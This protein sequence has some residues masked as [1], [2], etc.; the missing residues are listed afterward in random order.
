MKKRIA[1]L[2]STGSIGKTLIDILKQYK[3]D[4]KIVLLTT[5][6]NYKELFKQ[7]KLFK[8]KNVIIS[9]SKIY[10]FCRNHKIYKRFNISNRFNFNKLKLKK[11][12]DYTMS[13]ITGL[14][15]LRPTLELIKYSKKIA[16]ANKESIVCAWDI[17][18]KELKKNKTEFVPV[19]SEHFSLWYGLESNKKKNIER[20]YLTASGGPFLNLPLKKFAKI[21]ISNAT[22][23]PNW[24]M[25]NKISIDSATLMNKVFE[26]IEAKK[27]FEI[28]YNQISILIHSESY[29]HA[30]IKFKDGMSKIVA[31]DTSMEI[32][33]FNT[34]F[35]NQEKLI[36]TNKL[37]I[38]KLN[39][40]NFK[41]VDT[42]KFPVISILKKMPQKNTLFET[43]LVSANDSLVE[44]FLNKKIKFQE[45]SERLIKIINL[46]EF[47]KYKKIYPKNSKEIMDLHQYVSSKIKNL[48]I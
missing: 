44:L 23:H 35:S 19:D 17:I 34:I 40:L 43:V 15:G 18:F 47:K 1:I 10:N 20:I 30:I 32:P 29:V 22:N 12:I 39:N 45:I 28:P 11:K 5:N 37:N 48:S 21:S 36:K 2:G 25:G 46:K 27:I 24:S 31:H 14:D 4:N 38:K 8:V 42:K 16:I 9:D 13:S 33:I 3:K 6:K 7:A 26:V 41:K